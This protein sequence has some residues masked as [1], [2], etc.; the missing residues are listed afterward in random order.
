MDKRSESQFPI[1]HVNVI[2]GKEEREAEAQS[3]LE[4]KYAPEMQGN[5]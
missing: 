1:S 3:K 2:P 4:A 5:A